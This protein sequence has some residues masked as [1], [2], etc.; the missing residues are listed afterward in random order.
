M[1][2]TIYDVASR[3]GVSIST[4]SR[5]LNAPHTVNSATLERIHDAIDELGFVPKAEATARARRSHRQIGVLAPFFTLYPSFMQRMRGI[6]AAL[7]ETL[8]ELVVF[9]ADTVDHV[10]GYLHSLPVSRRL[11]GLIII[12]L[13]LDDREAERLLNHRLPAVMIEAVHPKLAGIEIDNVE[14]GRLA[15][16]YLYAKGHRRIGFVG[17]DQALPKYAIGT[18]ELR[19]KG[20]RAELEAN[21]LA[22]ITPTSAP[23]GPSREEAYHQACELL[24]QRDECPTA[25]FAANDTLALGV[26][27]ATRELRFRVPEDV[28]VVGFDDADF[29]DYI[30]LTTI[31]QSLEESGR[32]AVEMLLSVLSAPDRMARRIQLPLQIVERE[33][34]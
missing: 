2:A 13:V 12:S 23:V 6:A 15:A 14:G 19:Y 32:L 27:K 4:V 11:D 22:P 33:T 31:S 30:G 7:Q 25:I 10:R 21:G 34:G 3:A 17:G 20:F 28:A 9:N 16:K 8:F 1:T 24:Q 29:A 26:L 18:S 5:A